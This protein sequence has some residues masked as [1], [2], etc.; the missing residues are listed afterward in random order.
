MNIGDVIIHNDIKYIIIER[1][2]SDSVKL[3]SFE[4]DQTFN[5]TI[6]QQIDFEVIPKPKNVSW[7]FIARQNRPVDKKR[8]VL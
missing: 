4:T 3:K 1:I 8:G 2:N 6:G 5:M 7:L